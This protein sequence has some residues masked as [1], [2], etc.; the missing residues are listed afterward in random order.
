[1]IAHCAARGLR[2]ALAQCRKNSPM[3]TDARLQT[4][5]AGS[6]QHVCAKRRLVPQIPENLDDR[7][8][9]GVASGT[10]NGEMEAPIRH[11]LVLLARVLGGHFAENGLDLVQLLVCDESRR[12]GS[13]FAFEQAPRLDQ[14]EGPDVEIFRARLL[15][16][17]LTH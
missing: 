16:R 5:T 4:R 10:G 3:L 14:L 17:M 6:L 13:R 11:F 8:Y 15:R 1:M 12:Q 7:R 9:R 2:V